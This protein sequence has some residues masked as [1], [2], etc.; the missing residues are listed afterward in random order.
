MR[1][2]K[3]EEKVY[4]PGFFAES[5]VTEIVFLDLLQEWVMSR[6]KSYLS[7]WQVRCL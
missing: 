3:L 6:A 4:G 1:L 5:I 2:L 7:S